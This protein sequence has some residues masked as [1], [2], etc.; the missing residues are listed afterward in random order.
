MMCVEKV[1]LQVSTQNQSWV[2]FILYLKLSDTY[3]DINRMQ[4]T[5]L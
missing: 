5:F 1:C 4:K 3:L 2:S